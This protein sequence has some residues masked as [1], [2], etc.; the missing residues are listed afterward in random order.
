[1]IRHKSKYGVAGRFKLVAVRPDGS[2]RELAPWQDNLITNTGLDYLAGWSTTVDNSNNDSMIGYLVV[3]TGSTPP[4]PTDT[5][6]ANR[7]AIN[8]SDIAIQGS[9]TTTAPYYA[10]F[11][12]TFVF[13]AGVAAGNLTELGLTQ[14]PGTGTGISKT[15]LFS[16]ALIKNSSGDPITVTVLPDEIL[17]VT[18]EL[19]VYL[20]DVTDHKYTIMDGTTPVEITVRP[21]RVGTYGSTNWPTISSSSTFANLD[22]YL[23]GPQWMKGA[24]ALQPAFNATSAPGSN[25][26]NDT[27]WN[28]MWGTI[29]GAIGTRKVTTWLALSIERGAHAD[30]RYVY[31][32]SPATFGWSLGFNPTLNKAV[33]ET[34]RFEIESGWE[35]YDV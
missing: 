23:W 1:M 28:T 29:R 20:L 30:I 7:L 11:R 4:A 17:Q 14:R 24:A 27:S 10:W 9:G 26:G 35:R 21:Y 5:A 25:I 32:L 31:T 6:L 22:T 12:R 18:Y 16:R 15:F 13:N 34:L 8:N 19:R 3:G 2:T 33:D